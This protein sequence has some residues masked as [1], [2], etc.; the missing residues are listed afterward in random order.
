VIT[1]LAMEGTKIY[2]DNRHGGISTR[3]MGECGRE[4][5]A[6][7]EVMQ[8]PRFNFYYQ[9]VIID[10]RSFASLPRPSTRVLP[11]MF[12]HTGENKSKRGWSAPRTSCTLPCTKFSRKGRTQ[13][14]PITL[15]PPYASRF[16]LRLVVQT[17]LANSGQNEI[18]VDDSSHAV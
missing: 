4:K 1:C 10:G 14:L 2:T 13:I 15:F 5:W 8:Q 18:N 9:L 6:R 16:Y 12:D 7:A 3:E 11:Q 17:M